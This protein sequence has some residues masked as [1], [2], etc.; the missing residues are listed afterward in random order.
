MLITRIDLENLT[1]Q[2]NWSGKVNPQ[3]FQNIGTLYFVKHQMSP[4]PVGRPQN[5]FGSVVAK[6][7]TITL[8][9]SMQQ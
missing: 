2:N 1:I 9:I 3:T 8:V 5:K 7:Q 6:Q 4:R